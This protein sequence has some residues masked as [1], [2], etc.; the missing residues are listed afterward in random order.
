[1][2]LNE[3]LASKRIL[4]DHINDKNMSSCFG[5]SWTVED[6]SQLTLLAAMNGLVLIDTE[7]A[8]EMEQEP[9]LCGLIRIPTYGFHYVYPADQINNS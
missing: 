3:Y 9:L 6:L 5:D 7:K 4:T 8:F 2:T 1:M